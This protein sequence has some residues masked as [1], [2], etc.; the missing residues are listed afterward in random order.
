MNAP[1]YIFKANEK[2]SLPLHQVPLIEAGKTSLQGY[3][4]LVDNPDDCKIEIVQ[5]PAQGWRP[6]DDMTGDEAGWVEGIFHGSW[7]G[8]VLFGKNVP[9]IR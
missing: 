7:K 6:V 8:D 2:P 9:L 1:E 3:G 4:Y 5:W